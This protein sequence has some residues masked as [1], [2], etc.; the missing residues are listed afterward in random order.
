[1]KG[2]TPRLPKLGGGVGEGEVGEDRE[3]NDPTLPDSP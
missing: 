3:S 1:M 2:I